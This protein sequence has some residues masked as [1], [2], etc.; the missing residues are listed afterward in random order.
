MRDRSRAI[1]PMSADARQPVPKVSMADVER[2]VRR[3]FEPSRAGPGLGRSHPMRIPIL[4]CI[5]AL[6]GCASAGVGTD[7]DRTETSIV[8]LGSGEELRPRTIY[9]RAGT[10]R[11]RHWIPSGARLRETVL[12]GLDEANRHLTYRWTM[13][14]VY[15]VD[16]S[17]RY[18]HSLSGSIVGSD[19]LTSTLTYTELPDSA[20]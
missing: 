17:G 19:R 11:L 9:V 12:E 8:R 5:V 1:R 4:L 18:R 20:R 3:D 15:R 6:A 16:V 7:G 2:I 10:V 14:G 13:D